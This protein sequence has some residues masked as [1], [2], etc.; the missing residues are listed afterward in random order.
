MLKRFL[1]GF[2]LE[3]KDYSLY[4]SAFTHPSA[5]KNPADSYERLE[6][7]GD[8]VILIHVV[9]QLVKKHP[10]GRVGLLSKAKSRIVSGDTLAGVANDL[11]LDKFIRVDDSIQKFG[12]GISNGIMSDLFEALVGAIFLDL[13]YLKARKFMRMT[14][15]DVINVDLNKRRDEDFKSILQEEIQKI[16]KQIPQYELEKTA[17]PD[18]DKKFFMRVKFRGVNLGRGNG[19]NK[20]EAEQEA[21]AKTLK[22]LKYFLKQIDYISYK[23]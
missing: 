9:H 18:H 16:Y 1:A 13:G 6:F 2:G 3:P 23:K 4:F 7:L 22:R 8:S 15:V 21:A 12:K 10:D 19:R 17:G 14:L 11:K 20:K 5:S